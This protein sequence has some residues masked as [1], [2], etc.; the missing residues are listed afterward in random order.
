MMMTKNIVIENKII[1]ENALS[2][3][4]SIIMHQPELLE[5]LTNFSSGLI[6]SITNGRDFILNGLLFN[7]EDKIRNDF[8]NSFKALCSSS[9]R[10]P[11]NALNYILSLLAQNFTEVTN[12]PSSQFFSLFNQLIDLK[13]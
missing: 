3:I 12:R 5:L 9:N 4:S 10:G 1:A 6:P 8:K 13:E 2:L 11:G 7:A